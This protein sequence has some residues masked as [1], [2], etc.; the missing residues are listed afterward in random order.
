MKEALLTVQLERHLTK[1]RILEIYLNVVE[2]AP[3]VYGAEAA[4]LHSHR[5]SA[6]GLTARQ[7]A[8]LAACLPSPSSCGPGG[9]DGGAYRK[10]VE[11]IERRVAKADWVGREL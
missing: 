10:R 4:A 3:G 1:H 8:E 2:F 7:A 9:G 6:A 11:R 5:R